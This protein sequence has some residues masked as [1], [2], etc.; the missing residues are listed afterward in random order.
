MFAIV[1]WLD[2]KEVSAVPLKWL[3]QSEGELW[4]FWPSSSADIKALKNASDPNSSW[5]KYRVRQIGK[6]G[7][8]L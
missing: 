1:E 8:S 6:A 4:S 3:V 7:N 5:L 2:S